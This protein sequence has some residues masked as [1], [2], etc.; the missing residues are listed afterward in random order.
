MLPIDI[1]FGFNANTPGCSPY[2]PPLTI[3]DNH[4]HTVSSTEFTDYLS[5]TEE[6]RR[7]V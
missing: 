3:K 2:T 6:D 5:E 4:T 1:N 7:K